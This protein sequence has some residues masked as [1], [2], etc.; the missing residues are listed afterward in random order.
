MGTKWLESTDAA[1]LVG[2]SEV[3]LHTAALRGT[4]RS[5]ANPFTGTWMYEE[6]EI[7][8]LRNLVNVEM[9]RTFRQR[10]VK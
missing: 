3:A 10:G 6:N 5:I 1:E 2:C 8:R 7:K 9:Q 4:L